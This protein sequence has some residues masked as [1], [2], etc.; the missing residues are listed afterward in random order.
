MMNWVKRSWKAASSKYRIPLNLPA[1]MMV[2]TRSNQERIDALVDQNNR[3]RRMVI[4]T[5]SE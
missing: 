5:R 3:I 2:F 4:H 1:E